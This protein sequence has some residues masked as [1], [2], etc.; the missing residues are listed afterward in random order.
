MLSCIANAKAC[1]GGSKAPP[2]PQENIVIEL[3]LVMDS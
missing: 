3:S 2:I 1:S